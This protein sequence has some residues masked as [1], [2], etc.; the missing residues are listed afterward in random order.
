LSAKAELSHSNF[1]MSAAK[2]P[3]IDRVL[4]QALENGSTPGIAAIVNAG[5]EIAYRKAVGHAQIYPE[6]RPLTEETIFDVASLTKV[7]ATTTAVMLLL[8]DKQIALDDPLRKFLPDFPYTQITLT[9]LLTHSAGFPDHRPF[10][11]LIPAEQSGSPETTALILKNIYDTELI[12][13]PGKASKYS[14]LGF[15]LLGCAIEK[16][17]GTT[18][19][20]FCD[21]QIF[22][23]FGMTNT[24][25][26][27]VNGE[28][29]QGEFAATE[30]CNWR[31]TILC[32]DVH[33]ENA[34]ALGGVAGHAGLFSTLDDTH[35]FMMKLH[36]CYLGHD[37]TIPKS[38][39]KTF[40]TRQQRVADST[41]AF[42][43]DTP[44]R[45]LKE[46]ASGGTIISETSVGHT[47]F[48]GVSIWFD[49]PRKL[50]IILFAN[51]I[52]PSRHNQTFL[53]MRPKIHD[54]I[55]IAMERK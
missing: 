15:I 29:R 23:P 5:G 53:S 22:R 26:Q 49:L 3:Y 4:E 19:D 27:P 46:K 55:V 16:I 2:F 24:F 25:F 28:K 10:Y 1:N 47:G 54:T 39:V 31:N 52:H 34:Y 42:G 51:R 6:H 48:T 17:T 30:R 8:R 18:L 36:Q 21:E 32:G 37:E 44:S 9:H 35:R 43:W 7:M 40:F 45:N 38:I 11:E 14:D 20:R 13:A 41:R 12:Y 50:L 33:D